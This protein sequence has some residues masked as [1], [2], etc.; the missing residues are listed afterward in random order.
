MRDLATKV[1][2]SSNLTAA[3]FNSYI[4][5]L[6]N[7]VER[8]GITL[9]SGNGPDTDLFMLAEAMTRTAQAGQ[10][11][12][13]GGVANTFVLT[14]V[15][16]FEQPTAYFDGMIVSFKAAATNTGAC[17]INVAGIGSVNAT[18]AGGGAYTSAEIVAGNIIT[19]RFFEGSNRFE[20]VANT[21]PEAIGAAAP[22]QIAVYSDAGS[23]SAFSLTI[24][25][26]YT[27]PAAFTDQM[28]TIFRVATTNNGGTHSCANTGLGTRDVFEKDGSNPAAGRF[29]ADDWV[30]LV[31]REVRDA[32]EIAFVYDRPQPTAAVG[33]ITDTSSS[34]VYNF[35]LPPEARAPLDYF[36]G[37]LVAF[38]V[39][40]T[41]TGSV[42]INIAGLGTKDLRNAENGQNF[43]SGQLA[44]NAFAIAQFVESEDRFRCFIATRPT[45][46]EVLSEGIA[47]RSIATAI[48]F[49]PSTG[50]RTISFPTPE[51]DDLGMYDAVNGNHVVPAGVDRMDICVVVDPGSGPADGDTLAVVID[52]AGSLKGVGSAPGRSGGVDGVPLSLLDEPVSPGQIIDVRVQAT[53]GSTVEIDTIR[54]SLRPSKFS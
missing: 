38:R 36:D 43:T 3:E 4:D 2:A 30:M 27:A 42:D 51:F 1:D 31:F 41:N 33:L 52:I 49:T 50:E 8:A 47:T 19:T 14:A 15:Q 21:T 13:D 48:S 26:G 24:E 53:V 46:Q 35:N 39:P 9:D 10:S 23:A 25:T 29:T 37:W 12:Q 17:T 5:E 32:F 34:T 16:E 18:K 54:L 11:Y 20:E 40:Q 28:V 6:E 44:V 45:I 7:A 22:D